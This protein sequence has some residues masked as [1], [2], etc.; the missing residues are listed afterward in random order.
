M[1]ETM[2][3]MS[4]LATRPYAFPAPSSQCLLNLLKN[5]LL[6]LPLNL[7]ALVVRTR[8]AVESHQGSEVELGLLQQLD[9]ADVDLSKQKKVSTEIIGVNGAPKLPG[10]AF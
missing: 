5:T 1:T 9:L 2:P 10:Y 7:L 4:L 3:G 6:E 8:L